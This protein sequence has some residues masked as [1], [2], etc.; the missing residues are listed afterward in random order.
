MKCRLFFC[1]L[2]FLSGFNTF[3][4]SVKNENGSD[5]ENPQ[6]VFSSS[7]TQTEKEETE[8]QVKKH[9]GFD[10]YVFSPALGT[11]SAFEILKSDTEQGRFYSLG[12]SIKFDM[13][14]SLNSGFS[15]L[16][17]NEFFFPFSFNT[18]DKNMQGTSSAPYWHFGALFGYTHIAGLKKDIEITAAAGAGIMFIVPEVIFQFSL[19]KFFK[20][21]YGIYF[22]VND[23]LAFLPP[24]LAKEGRLGIANFTDLSLG[25]SFKVLP[26]PRIVKTSKPPKEKKPFKRTFEQYVFAPSLAVSTVFL[27]VPPYNDEWVGPSLNLDM[28]FTKEKSGFSFFIHNNTAVWFY[29]PAKKYRR[30]ENNDSPLA[31]LPLVFFHFMLGYTHGRGTS[32]EISAGIGPGFSFSPAHFFMPIVPFPGISTE[33]AFSKYFNKKFG[34]YFSAL[35][36][37]TFI[38]FGSSIDENGKRHNALLFADM[39]NISIGP[40]FRL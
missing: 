33:I 39:L 17:I 14:F 7:I 22:A 24:S 11:G 8:P 20:E 15:F 30:A 25:A 27:G 3:A 29:P 10:R 6:G 18:S 35:N 37:F 21:K 31:F 26:K 2:I 23:K 34:I 32:F 19:S 36:S 9:I 16:M 4:Q 12:P 5:S 13:N 28:I 40:S 1:M 38:P